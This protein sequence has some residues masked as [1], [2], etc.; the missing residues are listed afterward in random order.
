MTQPKGL[1]NNIKE[2]ISKPGVSQIG[3]AGKS[4]S[5]RRGRLNKSTRNGST[6]EGG[7]QVQLDR[8]GPTAGDK[9][10]VGVQVQRSYARPGQL[11][12]NH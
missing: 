10:S 9:G 5:D 1:G 11:D 6:E 3:K 8:G 4:I 2:I 12:L 7:Y